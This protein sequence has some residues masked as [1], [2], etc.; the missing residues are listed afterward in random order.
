MPFKFPWSRS[1]VPNI[2]G[3]PLDKYM[4]LGSTLLTDS[5]GGTFRIDFLASRKNLNRGRKA[6]VAELSHIKPLI[7]RSRWWHD[8]IKPWLAGGELVA[9]IGKPSDGLSAYI[10]ADRGWTWNPNRGWDKR[11]SPSEEVFH[12]GADGTVSASYGDASFEEPKRLSKELK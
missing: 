12:V 2:E 9:P 10:K 11:R 7:Q 1:P 8:N 6:I 4:Y 3:Y 5:K